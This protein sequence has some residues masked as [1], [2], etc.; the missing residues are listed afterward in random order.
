MIAP[1]EFKVRNCAA[2]IAR[3][4]V[5][6]AIL[7]SAGI[8][9]SHAQQGDGTTSPSKLVVGTLRVPPFVLRGDDGA[10]NG[11]SIELWNQIA[12]ELKVDF[13]YREFDYDLA[14]LLDALEQG[15]IDVAVAAIPVTLEGEARFDFSHPYFTAGVGIAVRAEQQPGMLSTLGSLVT[16]QALGTIAAL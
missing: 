4:W 1:M 5:V 15:K 13:Q 2:V 8:A 9:P 11:L 10:W 12:A 3:A 7:L 16:Y 6:L 14:G